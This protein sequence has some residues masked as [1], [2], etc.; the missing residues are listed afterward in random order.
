MASHRCQNPIHREH[1][2]GFGVAK[3]YEF[4]WVR[5]RRCE[6]YM[7]REQC[8]RGRTGRLYCPCCHGPVRTHK[9]NPGRDES[10]ARIE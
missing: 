4:G 8:Q 3:R 9:R 2:A 7:R 1:K 5:C 10:V 6:W